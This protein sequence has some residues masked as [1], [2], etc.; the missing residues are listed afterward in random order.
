MTVRRSLTVQAQPED[1]WRLVADPYHLPRWWPRTTRVEGVSGSGW[2]SVLTSE[3]GNS[4]RADYA[5]LGQEAGR[6]RAWALQLE[7]SPFER[8]FTRAETEVFLEPE[9]QATHVTLELRQD[10]KGWARLGGFMLR[11]AGRKQLDEALHGIAEA[12]Q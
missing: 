2:T 11:R 8:L 5:V 9:A 4:V 3:R 12:V 7:G 6:R 10:G 1:V